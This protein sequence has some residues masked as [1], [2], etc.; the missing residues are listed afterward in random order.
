M[1]RTAL[2]LGIVV[3]ASCASRPDGAPA[4]SPTNTS[5]TQPAPVRD[6]APSGP[7]SYTPE[8]KP[9]ARTRAVSQRWSVHVGATDH[10][11]TM[12]AD[13]GAL[14]IGTREGLVVLDAKTGARRNAMPALRGHVVGVALD[15]DRVIATSAGGELVAATRAGA[16]IFRTEIGAGAATP[17]TLADF[18]GDGTLDV[19]V[20]DMKG[21]ALVFDGKTGKRRW[22]HAL[23]GASDPHPSAGAGLA[24][25]DLD[26]DGTPEIV[27]GTESG[28]LGALRGKTGDTLWLV[29]RT[30]P[31]RAAPIVADVDADKKAEVIAGWAD[32]DVAIVDGKSGKEIWTQHVEEDDGD[33]T[34]LLATP[35]PLVGPR[36]GVLVVPTARWGTDDCVVLLG[37]H[38]RLRRSQQGRVTSSPVIGVVDPDEGV[39]EAVVGTQRGDVVSFAANGSA[40][41]LYHLASAIEAPMTF[42]DIE[43]DGTQELLV[44]TKDGNLTALA[45][46]VATAPVVARARGSAHND[47]VLPATDLGWKLP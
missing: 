43:G 46:H 35:T 22:A 23:S 38:D 4:S 42:A 14:F 41:L 17:P 33:P 24:A 47:G 36:A 25:A 40:S 12:V 32:G 2:A 16:P 9:K 45:L 19:A 8:T 18:D 15:K 11:T 7:Q 39:I 5:A 21:K 34:G 26:G 44:L 1:N 13:G 30:S 3:L 20:G 29:K 31:L 6:L 37:A 28:T 27:M 10:R